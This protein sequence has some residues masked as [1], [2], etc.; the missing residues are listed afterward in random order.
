MPQ[1]VKGFHQRLYAKIMFTSLSR[2]AKAVICISNFTK[3]ELLRYTGCDE[4]KMRLVLNGVDQTWRETSIAPN[5]YPKPY[6]LFV[7]NVK[8]N[9]NL[10][11]LLSAFA[12][13]KDQT[14]HNLV[15]V[16]K[17]EGFITGDESVF[18]KTSQLGPWVFYRIYRTVSLD[19]IL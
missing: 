16:G 3:K 13:I 6:F 14:N 2:K 5:P 8:P 17:K 15:I 9:K 7:G 19:S 18:A 1:L 12:L 4:R 10:T 11:N